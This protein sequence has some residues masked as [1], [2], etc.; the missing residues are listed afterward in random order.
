[1]ASA[2]SNQLSIQRN[3]G[4][5]PIRKCILSKFSLAIFGTRSARWKARH[6]LPAP[7]A[8]RCCLPA[9]PNTR[10]NLSL[11]PV[12]C[13]RM[14]REVLLS[15]VD[16]PL[17]ATSMPKL[18]NALIAAEQRGYCRAQCLE[19]VTNSSRSIWQWTITPSGQQW[20]H[21]PSPTPKRATR[22][23][24]NNRHKAYCGGRIGEF[25]PQNM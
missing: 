10:M 16:G 5:W 14:I 13:E 24:P 8:N 21:G 17:L 25:V 9:H 18:S 15:L 7:S 19:R 22:K 23:R 6:L 12:D 4:V 2:E 20:L 1:M 3:E 11:M